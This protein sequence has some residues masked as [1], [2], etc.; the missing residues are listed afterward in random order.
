MLKSGLCDSSTGVGT[1]IRINLEFLSISVS[2][3]HITSTS[4]ISCSAKISSIGDILLFI[5][6][7]FS[8]TTSSQK[9]SYFNDFAIAHA[10]GN[11]TYHIPTTTT[12]SL[13]IFLILLILFIIF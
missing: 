3:V 2:E 9:T 1:Q 8:F 6:S 13:F 10:A 7:I 11:H 4:F 5:I 12:F